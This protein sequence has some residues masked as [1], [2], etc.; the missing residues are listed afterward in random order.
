MTIDREDRH[1]STEGE[2]EQ[3]Q[4]ADTSTSGVVYV[5]WLPTEGEKA[6]R[7]QRVGDVYLLEVQGGSHNGGTL[8]L[9][10]ENGTAVFDMNHLRGFRAQEGV[11]VPAYEDSERQAADSEGE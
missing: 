8:V 11:D 2:G 1:G 7:S 3:E 10:Q 5:D 4:E 9:H 6:D